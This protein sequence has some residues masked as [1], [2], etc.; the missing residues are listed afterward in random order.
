MAAGASQKYSNFS[1]RLPKGTSHAHETANGSS[2]CLGLSSLI[3]NF[4]GFRKFICCTPSEA[5]SS[6]ME[7]L[8]RDI[9]YIQ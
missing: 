2:S 8:I 4:I 3:L 1:C 5:S 9:M 7:F 6:A